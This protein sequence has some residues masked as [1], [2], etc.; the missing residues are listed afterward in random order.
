MNQE[1]THIVALVA[2]VLFALRNQTSKREL[3]A[4]RA[5]EKSIVAFFEQRASSND[6]LRR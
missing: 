3:R 2:P 5:T 6:S 4:T 1:P